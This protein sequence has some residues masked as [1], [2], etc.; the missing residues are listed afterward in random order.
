MK[1]VW[2]VSLGERG[3]GATVKGVFEYV[4]LAKEL[5]KELREDTWFDPE[6]DYVTVKEWLVNET[7]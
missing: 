7:I 6:C 1:T 5:E 3:E 4:R 2:I